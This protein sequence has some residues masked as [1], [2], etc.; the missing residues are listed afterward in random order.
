MAVTGG[1]PTAEPPA[2]RLSSIG[3]RYPSPSQS[4]LT[5]KGN[6]HRPAPSDPATR[7]L[8]QTPAC[9]THTSCLQET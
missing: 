8:G 5:F 2:G 4:C 6:Q 3:G 9:N 7:C 1:Q